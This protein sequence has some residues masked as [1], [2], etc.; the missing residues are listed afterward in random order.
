MALLAVLV[1]SLAATASTK[2]G[3][4]IDAATQHFL[5]FYA[6][7]FALITLTAA[8]GIGLVAT[9]RIVISPGGRIISQAL[10][11]AVSFAAVAFLVIHIVFEVMVG[12]SDAGDAV[13]PFLDHGRTFY[14]GLGTIATDLL[15][16][17]VATGILRA[18]FAAMAPAWGWRALHALAYLAWPL[19]IMHGLLGGRHAQPYVDWSYGACAGAVGLALIFRVFAS[20]RRRPTASQPVPDRSALGGWPAIG[21]AQALGQVAVPRFAGHQMVGQQAAGQQVVGQQVVGQQVVGQQVAG[22]MAT[23]SLPAGKLP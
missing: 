20:T 15:I 17:I 13:V 6:G 7:V 11:R 3:R 22:P 4:A 21:P 9:D 23:S 1:G 16:L 10:H 19:A 2:P 12:R 8:V 18:R 5:L 14:L